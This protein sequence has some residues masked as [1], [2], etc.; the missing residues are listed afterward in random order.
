MSIPQ[1]QSPQRVDVLLAYYQAT[2]DDERQIQVQLV[3]LL[4]IG[5]SLLSIPYGIL[6]Q[7][8]PYN[9]AK[10]ALHLSTALLVTLPL[11]PLV[12]LAFAVTQIAIMTFKGY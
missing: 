3:A 1:S 9:T 12:V 2:R 7:A 5:V 6:F 11:I 4:A 8:A 10:N